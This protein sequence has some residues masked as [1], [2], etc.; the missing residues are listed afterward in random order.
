MGCYLERLGL[1]G[2][3]AAGA[4]SPTPAVTVLYDADA[5]CLALLIAFSPAQPV[6][7]ALVVRFAGVPAVLFFVRSNTSDPGLQTLHSLNAEEV[8]M[9]DSPGAQDG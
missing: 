7:L 1:S 2:A 9:R 8:R 5:R 3:A 4:H 6:V